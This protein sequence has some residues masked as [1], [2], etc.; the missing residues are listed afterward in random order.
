MAAA[1]SLRFLFIS[2]PWGAYVVTFQD[3]M[4]DIADFIEG[5]GFR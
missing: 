3:E 5:L 2:T 1:E 4:V